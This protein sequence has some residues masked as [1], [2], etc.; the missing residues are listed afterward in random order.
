[1]Q[2]I[3]DL[4]QRIQKVCEIIKSQS[5]TKY[6]KTYNNIIDSLTC[7]IYKSEKL[8]TNKNLNA[9]F[10]AVFFI[11]MTKGTVNKKNN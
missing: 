7:S 2:N 6:S 8:N 3:Q 10:V 1:M 11:Q 5:S 4:L 9:P